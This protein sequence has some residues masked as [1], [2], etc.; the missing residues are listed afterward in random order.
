MGFLEITFGPM[1]CGKSSDLI[2]SYNQT[3][4]SYPNK[5]IAINSDKDNRYG[6]DIIA[7]HNGQSI[8][9][10]SLHNLEQFYE[11]E[12]LKNKLDTA[13]YIFIDEAQFFTNLKEW[14]LEQVELYNKN[15]ML[16]GLVSDFKNEKFGEILDLIPHAD[17]ITKL[18]GNCNNCSNLSLYTHRLTSEIEQEVIGADN[19]IPVCRNCYFNLTTR[20]I[21]AAYRSQ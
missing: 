9:C 17:K 4:L 11:T 10:I 2:E 21:L 7:S 19:Y 6:V 5:T 18:Q 20:P 16:Y 8:N 14:V 1:K 13:E 15:I 12:H 3:Y